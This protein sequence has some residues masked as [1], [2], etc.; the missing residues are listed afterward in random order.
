MLRR[1]AKLSLFWCQMLMIQAV[2]PLELM[3]PFDHRNNLG[4]QCFG[5]LPLG[6]ELAAAFK[7]VQSVRLYE[8]GTVGWWGTVP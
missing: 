2:D 8:V 6:A 7:R 5:M 3:D 1:G 4:A